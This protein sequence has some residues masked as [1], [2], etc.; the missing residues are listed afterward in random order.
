MR[1][2]PSVSHVAAV[3]AG[4]LSSGEQ[5]RSL[6]LLTAQCQ[7]WGQGSMGYVAGGQC[8]GR[9]L[10]DKCRLNAAALHA[11]DVNVKELQ[12]YALSGYAHPVPRLNTGSVQAFLA[13]APERPKVC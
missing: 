6:Q 10:A 8:S 13:V 7:L 9:E 2:C 1:Y 12:K 4:W 5:A 3:L 11:G